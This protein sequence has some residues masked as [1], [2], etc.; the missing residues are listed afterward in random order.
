M[1]DIIEDNN[2]SLMNAI[3]IYNKRC[4]TARQQQ[5]GSS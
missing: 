5:R 3:N 1:I 2:I 4:L